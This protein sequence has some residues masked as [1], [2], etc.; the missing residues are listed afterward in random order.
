MK[1]EFTEEKSKGTKG[2]IT[3]GDINLEF[4]QLDL[5]SFSSVMAFIEAFKASGKKLHV[6]LCNA[7]LVHE[8][9]RIFLL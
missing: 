2:I 1:A 7:G 9:G 8:L 3:E 6:L 4:M 5:A